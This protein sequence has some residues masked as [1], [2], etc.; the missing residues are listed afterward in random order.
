VLFAGHSLIGRRREL[1]S[2]PFTLFIFLGVQLTFINIL[3]VLSAGL[4]L[5]LS[6]FIFHKHRESLA[7][8]LLSLLLLLYS[9]LFVRLL[10][11]DLNYFL[12]I[13]HLLLV[14][15]SI[16]FLMG[17]T[18]YLYS[19]YLMSSENQFMKKDWLHL[20]PFVLYILFISKDMLLSTDELAAILKQTDEASF[21]SE[22]IVFNWI[23]TI[24]VL[25]YIVFTLVRIRRYSSSIKQVYSSIEK[26]KLDWLRYITILIGIG[27]I[28]FMLENMFKMGG[29][30]VGESFE[31][32][33]IIFC[34]YVF[35]LG[36]MGLLKSE[37]FG[38]E[39]FSANVHEL[40]N[41]ET[42]NIDQTDPKETRYEKSGL[43]EEKAEEILANLNVMMTVEKPYIDNS[44][45]LNK[46]ADMLFVTPHNLSETINT[47]LN[48]N[49]FDYI[50]SYRVD[51]VKRLLKDPGKTN[52]TLLAIAM[53]A[54]FNSKSSFNSI[55]K[56]HAGTT[57]SEFRKSN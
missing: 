26:V 37:I 20:I 52:Y 43:T 4:G 30:Q 25:V 54:G 17:P 41:L 6:L 8:K 32:S 47:K 44:L 12:I 23:I 22:F 49:F 42:I 53:E 56:K 2:I 11:W 50:N 27:I 33:N 19:K 36:Y 18:H 51:E 1:L 48:Q 39:D 46:L 13:P 45:T 16:T 9:I 29:I 15:T 35:I 21:S 57:P 38:S 24:H 7:N 40:E 14:P 5:F 34:V 31:L 28:I 10:L 55:F 3:L